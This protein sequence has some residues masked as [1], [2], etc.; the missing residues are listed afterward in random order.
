[1]HLC[2]CQCKTGRLDRIVKILPVLVKPSA[3]DIADIPGCRE[4]CSIMRKLTLTF[5]VL[6]IGLGSTRILCLLLCYPKYKKKQTK[7]FF[8]P[9]SGRKGTVERGAESLHGGEVQ[10]KWLES[11]SLIRDSSH[12]AP[13]YMK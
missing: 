4:Q 7:C 3:K 5:F 11:S 1:L 2:G 13:W 12:T 8:C 10:A 6:S 9:E